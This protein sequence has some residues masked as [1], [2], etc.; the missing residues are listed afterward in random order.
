MEYVLFACAVFVALIVFFVNGTIESKKRKKRF[1][2]SLYENYGKNSEKEYPIGRLETIVS[3]YKQKKCDFYIDDITWNDLDMDRIFKKLDTTFSAAGEE[4]LYAMLRCPKFDLNE[5]S[6]QE[7]MIRYFM[8]QEKERVDVQTLCAS[9]G[10]TGRYS[11]FDYLGYLDNLK[12][13]KNGIH[14]L[15]I[16]LLCISL[17]VCFFNV[18]IG[19]MAFLVLM[20]TNLLAYFREKREIDPYITTM[21]YA[22]RVLCSVDGFVKSDI[23]GI[24]KETKRMQQIKKEFA[25]FLRASFL[26]TRTSDLSGN[27]LDLLVEYLKMGLHFDL[28]KFNQ[29]LKEM[30]KKQPLFIELVS[31]IGTIESNIAIGSFRK[32][33]KE[34]CVPELL[35]GY[36]ENDLDKGANVSMHE[37][38]MEQMYHPLITDPVCN[39]FS[40]NKGMLLTGSNASGKST[41]L[42]T[43]A[44]NA[45]L[46]QTIHTSCSKTYKANLFKVY[47][48]MSLKDDL[49]KKDSYFIVEIKALKRVI[50]SI[51]DTKIPVLC[52]VDEVL[53]GTNTVERITASTEILKSLCTNRSLCFAATHDIELTTLLEDYY[54]NYHF[55]E[56]IKEN[57]VLF[58]YQLMHGCATTRNAIKLLNIF[59]YDE[60]IIQNANNRAEV[61]LEKGTWVI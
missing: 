20:I 13:K 34:Y 43:V 17:V 40:E 33:C 22:V 38:E 31:F 58:N 52:F 47:S 54:H 9:I 16:L 12:E 23:E 14:Y 57:D 27:P 61:F 50:D 45:I 36:L 24:T 25:G 42:K 5:L 2:K 11:V 28:I 49:E 15:M 8:E 3:Y 59:G 56:Q 46:S 1:V 18:S 37:I 53:R 7:Q 60:T 19:M 51:K 6:E 30:K 48:S 4:A 26:I 55:E 44:L 39:S 32:S 21:A 29:M 41:F 10:R 35:N